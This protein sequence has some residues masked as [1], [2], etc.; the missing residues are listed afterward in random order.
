M[1]W[2]IIFGALLLASIILFVVG[3][4]SDSDYDSENWLVV[5]AIFFIAGGVPFFIMLISLAGI[6]SD[7]AKFKTDYAFTK[8]LIEDYE[9]GDDYGNTFSLTD[10]VLEINETIA[11]HRA[12]WDNGWYSAWRDREIGDLEPLTLPRKRAKDNPV[13]EQAKPNEE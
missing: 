6:K 4:V 2:L 8:A 9:A 10:K 12:Q 5:S 13:Q 11:K 1:N 7:F 3:V